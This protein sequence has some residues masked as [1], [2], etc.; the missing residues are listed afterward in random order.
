MLRK[1]RLGFTLIELM[2]V[3][4]IIGV[5][6]SLAI[7]RFTEASVRAKAAEAPRV[8]ASWESAFLAATVEVAS[9]STLA[10]GA[11][12]FDIPRSK[13]WRYELSG[14]GGTAK[15]EANPIA[16][17][18]KVK[19]G[20]DGAH[21]PAEYARTTFTLAREASGTQEGGDLVTAVAQDCFDRTGSPN[22]GR[23]MLAFMEGGCVD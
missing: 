20:E 11:A 8:L 7:P 23:L 10:A 1:N 18:G 21:N 4:V 6:A 13:W 12:A 19:A 17:M 14:S 5:L 15:A 3:I 22:V 9:V 16:N 2:V